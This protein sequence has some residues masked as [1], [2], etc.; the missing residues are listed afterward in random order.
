MYFRYFR[1][2]GKNN[3]PEGVSGRRVNFVDVPQNGVVALQSIL[4]STLLN[5]VKVGYNSVF[6]RTDGIARSVTGVDLSKAAINISGNTAN[7]A[8]AGQGSSAGTSNPGGLIRANSATNG[9]GQPYT[10]YS[11][12]FIDNLSWTKG[13]HNYKFGIEIRP[14]RLYTDRLGGVTYVFNSLPDF[15]A[16]RA[17]SVQYLGDVSEPSPFNG[18]ITRNRLAKSTYY[19]GYA[20]DEWKLRQN[21]TLNYGLRYEYFTPLEESGNAQVFFDTTNGA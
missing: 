12:S 4:T 17:A 18:G 15:L 7:F 19:I 8:I 20:Q 11:V 3:Q 9:R 6:S 14:N 2:Q 21:V 1:D 13:N 10:V 16:N 5:E